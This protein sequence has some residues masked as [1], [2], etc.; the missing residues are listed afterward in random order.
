MYILDALYTKNKSDMEIRRLYEK[1]LESHGKE[2]PVKIPFIGYEMATGSGKTVLM[3]A[4]ICYLL[5]QGI[6]NFLIIT[7]KSLDIYNKTIRNF[8]KGG[9][10]SIWEKDAQ[11]KF[12]LITGDDYSHFQFHSDKDFNLFIFNIDKFGPNASRTS[13]AWESSYFRDKNGNTI[14]V[15][16]FLE[17]E[18]LAIITDEAHHAQSLKE[19]GSGSIIKNFHP[20][21]VLEFTATALENVKSDEKRAQKVVYKYDIKRFLEDKYGKRIKAVALDTESIKRKKKTEIPDSEK[22]KLITLYLFHILKKKAVLLSE[23]TKNIKPLALIKVKDDSEYSET[24]YNYIINEL[25]HDESNIK[26]IL[27]KIQTEEIDVVPTLREVL[28]QEYQ[29]DLAVIMKEL[30]RIISGR[31]LLYSGDLDKE[32]KEGFAKIQSNFYESIVFIKRLDEGIDLPNIYTIAVINDNDSDFK[33]SVKQI[34]GRGVRLPKLTREYDDEIDILQ[35]QSEILHIICDRGKNFEKIIDDIKAELDL[36]EFLFSN[37]SKH[38]V[39][40][41]NRV[42][43]HLLKNKRIPIIKAMDKTRKDVTLEGLMSDISAVVHSYTQHNCSENQ[44]KTKVFLKF[45]P[46]SFFTIIDIFSDD[47]TFLKEMEKNG[48]PSEKFHLDEDD[49][50]EISARIIKKVPHIPD[51]DKYKNYIKSYIDDLIQREFYFFKSDEADKEIAKRKFKDSFCYFFDNYIHKHYYQPDYKQ[52]HEDQFFDLEDIFKDAEI[53]IHED[54]V[55]SRQKKKM[56]SLKNDRSKLTELVKLGHYFYQ[57]KHSLYDYTKFDSYTEK[58][59]ADYLEGLISRLENSDDCF[60][61]KSERQFSFQYGNQ[62]Y[63]PDF[64]FHYSGMMNIIET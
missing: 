20:K 9:S 44:E 40:E 18:D 42:K 30:K 63:F 56:E 41:I 47:F 61:V 5:E 51:S 60:W 57:Y 16:E 15:R 13:K 4:C 28:Q 34:I 6:K 22:W 32:Q 53:S 52:I 55:G 19:G 26:I 27:E 21:I 23:S 43:K 33:T 37:N 36:N 35:S 39:K 14:S 46:N 17:L 50:K 64:L 3:G 38:K 49:Y 2:N 62:R 24:V 12:N 10:D 48:I 29:F 25:Y 11:I 58:Q 54:A 59:L 45:A 1:L 31:T 7:P 8:T